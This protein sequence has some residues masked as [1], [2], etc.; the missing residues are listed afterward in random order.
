MARVPVTAARSSSRPKPVLSTLWAA[1]DPLWDSLVDV[2]RTDRPGSVPDLWRLW[3][4]S[5]GRRALVLRGSVTPAERY[6]DLVLVA[7]LKLGR[8]RP[9]VL[10]TDATW[11]VG[12]AALSRRWPRAASLLPLAARLFVRALDGEHV[13]YGVLST[14]ELES[15]PRTWGVPAS[16]VVFTGFAHSLWDGGEHLPT[17]DDG[18]LFAGGTSLRDYDLLEE[19]L[20]GT[21]VRAVVAADWRPSGTSTITAERVSHERFL[22]LLASC[23]ASVVPLQV[24]DRSA[25]QQT[26]LNAMA[27]AKPV[28]VTEAPGV[29][30][31]VTDGVTGL[32]VAPHPQALREAVLRVMAPEPD[33]AVA[34]MGRR[35]REVVLREHHEAAYRRRLLELVGVLAP[36]GQR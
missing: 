27:L 11:Q 25:G 21:G 20:E 7:L 9:P 12:S 26:Y 35:A 23:R 5:R 31:F 6:R 3:R 17:R 1:D 33:P 18:F 36:D 15:F 14:A 32:V 4:A 30:D 13:T 8:H 16:R 2:V 24:Q 29:A 28:V 10:V 34:A 22:E 19:A